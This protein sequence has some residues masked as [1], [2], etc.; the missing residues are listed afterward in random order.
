MC[1]AASSTSCSQVGCAH[2]CGSGASPGMVVTQ[3][4]TLASTP[5]MMS[6][7][8]QATPAQR[9]AHRVSAITPLFCANVVLGSVIAMAPKNELQPA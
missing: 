7:M 9:E 8:P 2:A 5:K 1:G 3:P 6:Q 4:P